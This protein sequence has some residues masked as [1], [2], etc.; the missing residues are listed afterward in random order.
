MNPLVRFFH[1]I[2]FYFRG[3]GLLIRYP[4]LFTLALFPIILTVL[5]FIGL[6]WGSSY[7]IG[8][9]LQQSQ[10][11]AVDGQLVIR[12]L[13]FLL[14]LFVMYLIYLPLTRIFLA[15]FSEKISHKT[16]TLSGATSLAKNELGFFR[17]IWEGVKLVALQLV[18]L[19]IV[20][21]FT[22]FLP[23]VGVPLG[24][25]VTICFCGI[26]FLDVPLSMRG[27]SMRHKFSL[28][29]HSRALVL[30]FALAGYLLLHIPILNLLVLPI[31]IIGATLLVNGVV[32]ESS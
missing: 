22:I 29:W 23:P 20:F 21:L 32:S 7:L 3:F 14:A 11:L 17:S 12:A 26:D 24:I 16:S 18:L 6:A 19:G 15:P 30:G 10:L 5:V 2:N 9:W 27:L 1:G 25:V 31:G 4:G 8:S 13:I 28:L